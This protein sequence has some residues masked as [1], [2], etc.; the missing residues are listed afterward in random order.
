[1][2]PSDNNRSLYQVKQ[3]SQWQVAYLGHNFLVVN[4][5]TRAVVHN[6]T[7]T[8]TTEVVLGRE[9][10]LEELEQLSSP[11][12]SLEQ[13]RAAVRNTAAQS[14]EG[15]GHVTRSFSPLGFQTG[16]VPP[17]NMT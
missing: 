3:S 17:G 14:W 11:R 7:V 8:F 9:H 13:Q 16:T 5:V 4:S 15:R 1:M 2:H 12:L 10:M 6:F